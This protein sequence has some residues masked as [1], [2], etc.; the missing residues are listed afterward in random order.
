M[1]PQTPLVEFRHAKA[2]NV[3]GDVWPIDDDGFRRLI[4]P[5]F[6]GVLFRHPHQGWIELTTCTECNAVEGWAVVHPV[7]EMAY[8]LPVA[9][10]PTSSVRVS[11]QFR[12]VMWRGHPDPQFIDA[13]E[14][15]GNA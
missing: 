3:P 2:W 5:A 7:R 14:V 10:D 1:I 12:L 15:A 4:S 11:G 6:V 13:L 8:A 9:G